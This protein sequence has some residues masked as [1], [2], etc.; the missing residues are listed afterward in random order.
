MVPAVASHVFTPINTSLAML[1]S[2][3]HLTEAR[4]A[5][6]DP[7]KLAYEFHAELAA[8]IIAAC[9]KAKRQT[10]IRRAALSGGVFQNR[11]LLELVDEGLREKGFQVLKHSLIPPNDGGIALVQAVYGMAYINR[12]TGLEV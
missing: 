3:S 4:L 7:R 5:G 1:G 11:L 2:V 6:E 10:G 8:E 12:N 9:E